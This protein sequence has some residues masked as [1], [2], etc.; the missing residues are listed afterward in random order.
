MTPDAVRAA[1]LDQ[2]RFCENSNTPLTV[3]VLRAALGALD[4]GSAT[5]RRVL[6][7]SGNARGSGDSVPLR[8]AGGLHALARAGVDPALSRLYAGEL[9]LA[10][11]VIP[12]MLARFDAQLLPWLDLPPQTNETGRAAAIM[13]A[14]LLL[15][16]DFGLPF[17]LVE[18]GASAGLNLNMDRFGYRLGD[19]IAGDP[20]APVQLAPVWHGDSPPAARVEVVA[21]RGVDQAPIIVSDPAERERLIAYCWADQPDRMARLE[22][23]LALADRFPP[24]LARGDAA[25]FAEAALAEPQAEGVARVVY[26]TIFWTY[27][28]PDKQARIEAALARAGAVATRDRPLA[29]ARYE[30][31]GEG[32][33][34]GL[35]LTVWPGG[36][37]RRLATG[38]PHV[39]HLEWR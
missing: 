4:R 24:P 9:G 2:I 17:E 33:V 13:A 18:L 15:A 30:L 38:H 10:E 20:A 28:P 3:A 21:R 7:W 26:H 32:G 25:D 22:A 27:L 1:F 29:W 34:A 23:A 37:T 12:D 14:L 8:L 39:K 36:K 35:W 5:G 6:A 16:D 11:T 31:T 19:M